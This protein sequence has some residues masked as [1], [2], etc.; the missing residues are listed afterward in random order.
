GLNDFIITTVLIDSLTA[1]G[2]VIYGKQRLFDAIVNI[3]NHMMNPK[4]GYSITGLNGVITSQSVTGNFDADKDGIDDLIIAGPSEFN[5]NVLGFIAFGGSRLK[6]N[7]D[8]ND[9]ISSSDMFHIY[10][11]SSKGRCL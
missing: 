9:T 4:N 5:D 10:V 2:H 8:L 3:N 6:S 1:V 7:V 11:A